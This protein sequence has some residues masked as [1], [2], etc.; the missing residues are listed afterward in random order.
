MVVVSLRFAEIADF[1]ESFID[2][3]RENKELGLLSMFLFFWVATP[4][5][6]PRAIMTIGGGFI[7]YKV[8]DGVVWKAIVV[9]TPI[10]YF[11]TW[12]GSVFA[13]IIG[14]YVFR[15]FAIRMSLRFKLIRAFE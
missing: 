11:G 12:I 13:F 2:W 4:L 7:V 15:D 10:I 6:V 8:Y 14:R 1:I 3:M 5:G 9:S